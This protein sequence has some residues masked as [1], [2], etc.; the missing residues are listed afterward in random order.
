VKQVLQALDAMGAK[1]GKKEWLVQ[2]EQR[3]RSGVPVHLLDVA[4]LDGISKVKGQKLYDHGLTTL[5]EVAA[6]VPRIIQALSCTAKAAEK[7]A[8]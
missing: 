5:T 4:R 7:I 2:L 6:N 3:I 1:W 8:G